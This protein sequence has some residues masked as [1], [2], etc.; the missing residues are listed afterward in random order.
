MARN[1]ELA[2]P[3]QWVTGKYSGVDLSNGQEK[4]VVCVRDAAI[5][6]NLYYQVGVINQVSGETAWGDSSVK[7]DTGQYP[8]VA[9]MM[10]G[11]KLYAVEVHLSDHFNNC[12]YKLGEVITEGKSI[13]WGPTVSLGR[14]KNPKLAANDNGIVIAVKEMSWAFSDYLQLVIGKFNPNT[15]EID[16]KPDLTV[17]DFWGVEPDVAINLKKIVIACRSNGM[18]RFKMGNIKDDLSIGWVGASC[19]LPQ[20]GRSPSIALNSHDTIVEANQTW[21]LRMLSHCTGQVLEDSI[22]WGEIKVPDYGEYPCISLSDDGTYF[23]VHK[24]P[25]GNELFYRN[26]ELKN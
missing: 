12:Y 8:S 16:W 21:T 22:L 18:I 7:Y 24:T 4:V 25:L 26:G 10:M 19:E 3:T 14:G 6:S 17:P 1:L 23:E 15:M 20:G 2:L 5:D 9:L 13:L 11:D